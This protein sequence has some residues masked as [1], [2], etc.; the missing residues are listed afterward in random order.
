MPERLSRAE[1]KWRF[2]DIC[3]REMKL[4]VD[5]ND[6]IVSSI[7]DSVFTIKDKFL[8]YFEDEEY[9]ILGYNEIEFNLLE[10]T[11]LMEMMFG[12]WVKLYD[13]DH[14]RKTIAYYQ[15]NL[16]GSSKGFFTVTYLDNND[17][18]CH[19]LKSKV[20]LNEN[21]RIFHAISLLNHTEHLYEK[22]L[23]QFDINIYSK[24]R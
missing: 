1:L 17:N 10:N 24:R 3:M 12:I 16:S 2:N 6:Y 20:F 21:L 4:D 7:T 18:K 14:A 13:V 19:E 15:T 23:S 8:K 5:E 9:P 22:S 11:R